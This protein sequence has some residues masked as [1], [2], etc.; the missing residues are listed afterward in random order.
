VLGALDPSLGIGTLAVIGGVSGGLGD[1]LGQEITMHNDPCTKYN[2]GSTAGAIA[3][4]ALSG[5]ETVA[6]SPWGDVM[7]EW[8][9]T[10][11]ANVLFTAPA[12][13]LP[14]VGAE[15]WNR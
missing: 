6:L 15:M 3:A 7:G 12:T 11:L 2:W 10:T 4:G 8:T 9:A 14:T 1:L 13:V 5:Y